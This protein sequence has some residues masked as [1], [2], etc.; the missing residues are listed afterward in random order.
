M[1]GVILDFVLI[2]LIINVTAHPE[3]YLKLLI[4]SN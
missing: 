1:G 3:I 4:I 2:N